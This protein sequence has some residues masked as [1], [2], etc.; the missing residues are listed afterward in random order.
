MDLITYPL[1]DSI[2]CTPV[3]AL[4]AGSGILSAVGGHQSASA[5]A[6]ANNEAAINNY[7]YQIAQRENEWRQ[8]L[9]AWGH[10]KIQ[11]EAQTGENFMAA[12]RGYS[13]EQ[14]RLN[15]IYQKAAF[16]N[17]DQLAKMLS[18]QGK[19]LASGA[20]GQSAQR[21]NAMMLAALGRSQAQTAASL[22]S[23]R[24][25]YTTRV[26]G[27]RDELT[28]ANREAFS[29]VALKPVAGIAP[30]APVMESGPSALSP[31]SYTH[32]TLPTKA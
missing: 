17:Q 10:K 31:V 16:T 2:V 18:S 6:R 21:S 7:E 9:T 22:T 12:N 20:Q 8:T 3:A 28:S 25:A 13:Q 11:Y 15:E 32:L 23:A 5:A 4:T 19:N 26:D 30:P 14:Q 1:Q 27:I 29:S 24:N